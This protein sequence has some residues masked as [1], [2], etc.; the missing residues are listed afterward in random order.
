MGDSHDRS[1]TSKYAAGTVATAAGAGGAYAATRGHGDDKQEPK[2]AESKPAEQ[3]A[4]E[5][6]TTKPQQHTQTQPHEETG[7]SGLMGTVKPRMAPGGQ[8]MHTCTE[9]GKENDI[10]KYFK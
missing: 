9:S 3:R 6:D 5:Q 4:L 10:S 7:K 2:L 8:M 1:N